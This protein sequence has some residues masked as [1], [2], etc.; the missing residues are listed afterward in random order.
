MRARPRDT[1]VGFA[2][3]V[4]RYPVVT[5]TLRPK[6]RCCFEKTGRAS[7]LCAHGAKREFA[8]KTPPQDATP[9]PSVGT[10]SAAPRSQSN[11]VLS[12]ATAGHTEE[13]L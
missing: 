10:N 2:P 6:K 1:F 13:K 7:F 8:V 11:S 9:L 3:S 4:E 12:P 5:E